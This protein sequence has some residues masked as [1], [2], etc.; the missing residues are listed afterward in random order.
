MKLSELNLECDDDQPLIKVCKLDIWIDELDSL[1]VDFVKLDAEGSEM[2][3]VDGGQTFFDSQDPLIMFE[4]KHGQRVQIELI[5]T[6]EKM[7]Y[8]IFQYWPGVNSLIP[9]DTRNS[10]T[11]DSMRLNLYAAKP[12]RQKILNDHRLLFRKSDTYS[13]GVPK[14]FFKTSFHE[15]IGF[16][17]EQLSNWNESSSSLSK[18]I[19]QAVMIYEDESI[20]LQFRVDAMHEA[21]ELISSVKSIERL[22]ISDTFS[23]IRVSKDL[24]NYNYAA[25]IALKMLQ[26]IQSGE[27]II[28]KEPFVSLD[29]ASEKKLETY[30]LD[31]WV[32]LVLVE[33]LELCST[34]SGI[35]SAE[36][37]LNR[38]DI[39]ER[40]GFLSPLLSR[41]HVLLKKLIRGEFT[42]L[43]K[44]S[45]SHSLNKTFWSKS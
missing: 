39:L 31:Q 5:E 22:T 21:E 19:F 41:R 27:G 32:Q 10:R 15:K 16:N 6:L 25:M 4:L 17:N 30:S 42:P 13:N 28:I 20:D 7:G 37:S 29:L 2:S 23:L 24:G 11:F 38:C 1:G 12:S 40:F 9:V 43:T 8:E 34:F 14:A 44:E 35:F 36:V 3:I 18:K 26:R 45:L 33:T